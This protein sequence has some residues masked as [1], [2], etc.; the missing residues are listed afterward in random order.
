[1]DE[2]FFTVI[3]PTYNR[4]DRIAV[5]IAS[6]LLQ[7]F[8]NFELIVIDDGSTDNTREIISMIKD[9]RLIYRQTKNRE[10]AAARNLGVS[11]ACG[12][13]VT[14]LDSDDQLYPDHL[15]V[16]KENLLALNQPE[17]YHQGYLVVDEA[18]KVLSRVVLKQ[19][20]INELLFTR[21]NVMS[22]MGV[23][24]KRQTARSNPF[25]EDRVLAGVE[26]WELWIRLAGQFNIHHGATITGALLHH[27]NRSVSRVSEAD[28]VDRMR[29]LMSRV[30]ENTLLT[31]KHPELVRLL[32]ANT[33]TYMSLHLTEIPGH[34]AS[35][36]RH[37]FQ[38]VIKQ[39]TVLLKRRTLAIL[40]NILWR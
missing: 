37:L 34:K 16:A 11:L 36:I 26:D 9:D 25:N 10:R 28:L 27:G 24:M 39:P 35:A 40:R 1:M 5:T 4:A 30:S 6:V 3:I 19:S 29:A 20:P 33:K 32:D 22:C 18:G 13:Y 7:D 12:T 15:A 31:Q 17:V 8:R 23:F 21:G 38:A 2:P 14:F